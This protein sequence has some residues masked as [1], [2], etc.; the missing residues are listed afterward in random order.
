MIGDPETIV[1]AYEAGRILKILLVRISR[2]GDLLFTTPAVRCLKARFPRAEFHFLTNPYSAQVL[3]GNPYISHVHLLNRKGFG[4]RLFRTAHVISDLKSTHID[5]VI[6]FRWRNEYRGL[7]GRINAPFVYRLS[8]DNSP[9]ERSKHMADRFVSGLAL[10]GVEPDARGMELFYAD[11][12]VAGVKEF[13]STH[14]LDNARLVVLHVGCHQTMK[15]KRINSGTKRTWPIDHW[16]DLVRKIFKRNGVPPI[17]TGFSKGDIALNDMIIRMSGVHAPQFTKKSLNSLAALLSRADGFICGDTGPL[18]VASA[19]GAPTVALFGP[20]NPEV[21][22]SYR[23]AGGAVV[24]QKQIHC[25]PCKGKGIKCRDNI[26]M[27]RITSQE[28]CETLFELMGASGNPD[29][30]DNAISRSTV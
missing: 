22:G 14:G 19:V 20:S 10:L 11:V 4:W 8:S 27:Q 1:E 29:S 28:V 2:V 18:H 30:T 5:L 21:T 13:L 25:A 12:D 3:A 15:V 9:M 17:L 24:L 6:P 7:F 16:V 23:N 26:C